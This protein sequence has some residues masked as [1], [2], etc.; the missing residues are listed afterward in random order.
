MFQALLVKMLP[1]MISQVT[2][3]IKES[4]RS[5][6]KDLESKAKA[7]PNPFDDMFVE[8]LKELLNV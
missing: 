6:L 8:L 7:T 2:P 3:T 1:L 5:I 4:A